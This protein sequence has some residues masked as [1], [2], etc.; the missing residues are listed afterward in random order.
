MP[1]RCDGLIW[2]VTGAVFVATAAGCSTDGKSVHPT[3]A[4][5]S[6]APSAHST[7]SATSA[8]TNLESSTSGEVVPQ[9]SVHGD[10][11]LILAA[12]PFYASTVKAP[13]KSLDLD[14]YSRQINGSGLLVS[15]IH[16]VA[17]TASKVAQPVKLVWLG[18]DAVVKIDDM[19]ACSS[20]C[21][22]ISGPSDAERLL[23]ASPRAVASIGVDT[24]I[25][26]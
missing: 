22:S 24:P 13:G 10:P 8:P 26:K 14:N 2:V 20:S 7:S 11:A 15:D 18:K 23:V 17:V 5:S 4:A 19:K 25:E 16:G 6:T 21:P 3:T 9:P 1:L 12:V